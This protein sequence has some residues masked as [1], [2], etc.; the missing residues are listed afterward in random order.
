MRKTISQGTAASA[1]EI[2]VKYL[3]HTPE[4]LPALSEVFPKDRSTASVVEFHSQLCK[5]MEENGIAF[6]GIKVISPTNEAVRRLGGTKP[7]CVP[8][9]Q[10]MFEGNMFLLKHRRIQYVEA[11]IGFTVDNSTPSQ[12]HGC[13]SF[14][15][16]LEVSGSRF[17]FFPPFLHDF[18]C[19]LGG[20]EGFAAG[21]A[22]KLSEDTIGSVA[23][24]NC[25]ITFEDEPLMIGGGKLCMGDPFVAVSRAFEYAD[26]L[27]FSLS[28]K[29]IILCTGVSARTPAQLGRY[30]FEW[31]L[32][33]SVAC[34]IT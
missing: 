23:N 21:P 29:H 4:D 5:V 11:A 13:S 6:K 28:N 31:G 8:I 2:Y 25:V 24:H 22:N 19:D 16:S 1:A 14:F 32:L 34:S 27:G 33:G 17:P 7:V 20:A 15:P 9:F 26:L 3:K 10:N 18:A 12:Y 30:S